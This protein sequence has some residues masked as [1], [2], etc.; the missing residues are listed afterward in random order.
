MREI[1][2]EARARGKK[3][4]ERAVISHMNRPITREFRVLRRKRSVINCLL[5]YNLSPICCTGLL[6]CVIVVVI[7][8]IEIKRRTRYYRSCYARRLLFCSTLINRCGRSLCSDQTN[9]LKRFNEY[10]MNDSRINVN[11]VRWS[12][13]VC[14]CVWS[15]SVGVTYGTIPY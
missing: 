14:V 15:L 7:N 8:T 11:S 9:R 6:A 5:I 4:R 12:L 1:C 13:C 3:R 10:K 2:R